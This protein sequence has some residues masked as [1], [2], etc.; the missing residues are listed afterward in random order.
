LESRVLFDGKK[1]DERLGR[2]PRILEDRSSECP[3][4]SLPE[5]S[6]RVGQPVEGAVVVE[7]LIDQRRK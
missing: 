7:D 5:L 6:V 2:V 3:T 4:V 1:G